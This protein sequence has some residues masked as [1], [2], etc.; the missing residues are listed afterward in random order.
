MSGLQPANLP[1]AGPLPGAGAHGGDG[2]AIA[3]WLGVSP[4]AILDLSAR[5]AFGCPA[6]LAQPSSRRDWSARRAA[7]RAW[8]PLDSVLSYPARMIPWT[9]LSAFLPR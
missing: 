1:P 3:A 8:S 2:P 4:D 7:L 9:G 6:W 5:I